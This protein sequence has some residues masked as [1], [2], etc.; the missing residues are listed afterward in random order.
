MT[1]S[2]H[3]IAAGGGAEGGGDWSETFA[4]SGT[5]FAVSV[6]DVCGHDDDASKMMV[7]LRRD[8][9]SEACA[10]RDPARVLSAVNE[11]LCRRGWSRYATSIFGVLDTEKRT[12]VFA[13]AGHPAPF[14]MDR[15]QAGFLRV[16]L[17]DM[18]LGVQGSLQIEAH[19]VELEDDAL[20]VFYTD[21]VTE[22]ERDAVVGETR[23]REAVRVAYRVPGIE[24]AYVIARHLRLRQRRVDDASILTV[25]TVRRPFRNGN[26][27]P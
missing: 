21:G 4:L 6:G 25:R 18:P 26:G 23:L 22:M 13:S 15:A 8:I 2:H 17:G 19:H 7:Q 24:P 9:R 20:L 5:Q 16:P 10:S 3:S 12:L 1:L 27:R 11:N 14:L